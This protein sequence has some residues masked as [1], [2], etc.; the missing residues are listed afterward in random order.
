MPAVAVLLHLRQA[1]EDVAVLVGVVDVVGREEQAAVGYLQP[2]VPLRIAQ[3][4]GVLELDA[5]GSAQDVPRLPVGTDHVVFERP[6]RRH[7]ALQHADPARAGLPDQVHRRGN[8]L[9]VRVVRVADGST[10]HQ[11]L[12]LAGEVDLDAD[13]LPVDE[14]PEAANPV[15]HLLHGRQ[16]FGGVV[17]RAPG[18]RH[19]GRRGAS[20]MKPRCPGQPRTGDDRR[21]LEQPLSARLKL[22]HAVTPWRRAL[23]SAVVLHDARFTETAACNIARV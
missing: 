17:R 12:G 10:V 23:S 3:E 1:D 9:R 6:G 19:R 21:R 13:R 5:G 14:A 15:E 18:D 22:P 8:H 2:R 11:A 16:Q 20:R 7:R 4:V